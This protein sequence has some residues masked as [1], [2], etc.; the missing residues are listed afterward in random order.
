MLHHLKRNSAGV[1]FL[2]NWIVVC[3]QML[4]LLSVVSLGFR[5]SESS[6]SCK[7]F[8]S[9]QN[10]IFQLSMVIRGLWSWFVEHQEV[11]SGIYCGTF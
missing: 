5:V 3:S 4:K 8:A 9:H 2:D 11:P 10:N 7:P 6:T 1:S